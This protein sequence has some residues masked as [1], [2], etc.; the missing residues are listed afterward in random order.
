V[1]GDRE[2][3]AFRNVGAQR[4]LAGFS[5]LI[6]LLGVAGL[7]GGGGV[8]GPIVSAAERCAAAV[9]Q[10]ILSSGW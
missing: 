10:P 8:I 3:V 2:A 5:T 6:G 4:A 1:T 7:L 9:G